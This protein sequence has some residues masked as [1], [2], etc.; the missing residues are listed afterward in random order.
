MRSP[1]HLK[2]K[3]RENGVADD[4]RTL[5]K[6]RGAD[7]IKKRSTRSNQRGGVL[8]DETL[9]LTHAGRI[10]VTGPQ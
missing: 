8:E 1:L 9:R 6:E 7:R 2:I 10:F 5:V 4:L 3:S